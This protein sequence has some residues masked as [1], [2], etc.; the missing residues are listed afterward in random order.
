MGSAYSGNAAG[1]NFAAF[2]NKRRKETRIFIINVVDFLD[3]EPAKLLAP[4][5]LFLGR[6][7]FVAAGGAHGSADGS[8]ASLLSH[9]SS[10]S[11]LRAQPAR[12]LQVQ[13]R[14]ARGVRA[15]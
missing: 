10:P 1:S 6:D 3:A 14:R 5:I 9:I 11:P 8:S 15:L 13:G 12:V 7:R 4:E 2:R